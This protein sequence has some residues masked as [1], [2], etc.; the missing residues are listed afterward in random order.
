G[1]WPDCARV[2]RS[3]RCRP[4]APADPRDALR[5]FERWP[6]W[7]WANEEMVDLCR[8][9][10]DHNA[11]REESARVGFYR[12]DVYSLWESLREIILHLREHDPQLV[13][14][15]LAAYQCFEPYHENEQRYAL[16]TRFVPTSCE[17]EVLDLLVRLR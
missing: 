8:W 1:D 6:T 9:L 5:A 17:G 2:D 16:A 10:R 14:A 3:I 11:G 12:L 13:P 15:A 7:M 4:D